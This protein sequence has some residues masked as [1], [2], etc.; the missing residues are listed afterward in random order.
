MCQATFTMKIAKNCGIMVNVNK[1]AWLLCAK[2][3]VLYNVH[4][5]ACGFLYKPKN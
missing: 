2:L 4:K 3:S 1:K 5:L